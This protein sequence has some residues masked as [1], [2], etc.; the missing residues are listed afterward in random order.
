MRK[1]PYSLTSILGAVFLYL[2]QTI[3]VMGTWLLLAFAP[4]WSV[5]MVN[6]AFVGVAIEVFTKRVSR[7]WLLLPS[8]WFGAYTAYAAFERYEIFQVGRQLEVANATVRV[9]FHTATQ[10]LVFSKDDGDPD[11]LVGNYN[12]PVAYVS[13]TGREEADHWSVRIVSKNVCEKVEAELPFQTSSTLV[14]GVVDDAEGQYTGNLDMKFCYLRRPEDPRKQVIKIE[15]ISSERKIG[16]IPATF[17]T[18]ILTTPDNH[19]WVIKGGHAL[20][21]TWFPMPVMGCVGEWTND[22]SQRCGI[23]FFRTRMAPINPKGSQ[24]R[25]DIVAL[26]QALGLR[27]IAAS[28]RTAAD[29]SFLDPDFA[30]ARA[31]DLKQEHTILQRLL[32]DP[33]KSTPLSAFQ[34]LSQKPAELDPLANKLLSGFMQAVKTGRGGENNGLNFSVLLASLSPAS[35]AE[36]GPQ[37]LRVLEAYNP[38]WSERASA[39]IE[40]FG[41]LGVSAAPLLERLLAADD[42]VFAAAAGICR[43]GQSVPPSLAARLRARLQDPDRLTREEIEMLYVASRR[44]GIDVTGPR[45]KASKLAQPASIRWAEVNTHTSPAVCETQDGALRVGRESGS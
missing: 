2:I 21:L 14:S 42:A 27:R 32:A 4:L 38:A 16:L 13:N 37:A 31:A 9:P 5:A 41:D 17:T 20:P 29:P 19:H 1:I 3:P 24:F 18:T 44:V 25:S 28:R 34:Q 26:A 43:I 8:L 6:G 45:F 10:D 40:R 39:L 30:R 15:R 12:L 23:G 7:W 35:F 11:W 22:D 36:A 33:A